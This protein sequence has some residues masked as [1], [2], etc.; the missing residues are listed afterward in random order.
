MP[1]KL[2]FD[3]TQGV[4]TLVID[5]SYSREDMMQDTL[6]VKQYQA[7]VKR[8]RLLVD[9]RRATLEMSMA[10]MFDF[11]DRI[12]IEQSM[13]TANLLALLPPE[14]PRGKK[15]AEFYVN[16]RENRGRLVKV[17]DST[18]DALGWLVSFDDS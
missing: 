6:A 14:S 11:P 8:I 9:A 16:A 10:D 5:G 12:Y 13:D 17:F 1:Q 3:K 15:Y 2:T 7:R 4:L 18:V